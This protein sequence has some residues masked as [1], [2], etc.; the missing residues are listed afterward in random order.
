MEHI[1]FDVAEIMGRVASSLNNKGIKIL[2]GETAATDC[3]DTIYL[4]Q[5]VK[6]FLTPSEV[7]LMRYFFLH[8]Q[9]HID[10]TSPNSGIQAEPPI[11]RVILNAIEDVRIEGYLVHCKSYIRGSLRPRPAH[12]KKGQCDRRP[13]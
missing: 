1:K 6:R 3:R 11:K 12:A 10:N 13:C 7:S 9:G 2:V 5:G 8:E 4:P